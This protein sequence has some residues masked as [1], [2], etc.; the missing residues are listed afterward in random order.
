MN[1]GDKPIY[2]SEYVYPWKGEGVGTTLFDLNWYACATEQGMIKV[3][4]T[5]SLLS[6]LNSLSFW[7]G[8]L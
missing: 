8:K 1:Q 5:T 7:T 2:E 3:G 4:Y 6:I